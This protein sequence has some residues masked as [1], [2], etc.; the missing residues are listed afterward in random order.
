MKLKLIDPSKATVTKG[1]Y[2]ENAPGAPRCDHPDIT[3]DKHYLIRFDH[4]NKDEPCYELGRFKRVWFGWTFVGAWMFH[5]LN[6]IWE[7]KYGA[8][9]EVVE[10]PSPEDEEPT[11]DCDRCC[12]DYVPPDFGTVD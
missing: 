10:F 1:A 9:W 5:Q 11:C 3:A 4:A 8:V 7:Y 6:H 12:D 2:D